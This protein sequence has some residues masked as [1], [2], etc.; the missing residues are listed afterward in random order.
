MI[1]N[2]EAQRQPGGAPGRV[3]TLDG[4]RALA[5]LGVIFV[6]LEGTRGLP[7]WLNSTLAS[8]PLDIEQL[9]VRVFFVLSGFLITTILAREWSRDGRI[10]LRR[11]YF[12]RGMKI[13]PP[14]IVFLGVLTLASA[15]GW[16]V[17][18]A[19][20]LLHSATF[21][22][23]YVADRSWSVGHLWALAIEEQFYLLWP[24]ALVLAGLAGGRRIA[25]VAICL[26]PLI[27]LGVAAF[28]PEWT[29]LI[30]NTF[31]TSAD[32]LAIGCLLALERD[33]LHS[34]AFVRRVIDSRWIIPVIFVVG[35]LLSQRFRPGLLLGVPLQNIA[36]ALAVER[37]TRRPDGR[38]GR[39]LQWRGLVFI[40]TISYSMYLWQQIFLNRH[41]DAP[42]A[43][44]PLNL[45]LVAVVTLLSY[46]LVERP[47]LRW[48]PSLE[49]RLF[50]VPPST[51]AQAP[52]I[53]A[54]RGDAPPGMARVVLAPAQN[55]V[56][57]S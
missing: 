28:L 21:T 54:S 55:R 23:N 5:M 46:Y 15:V 9:R 6:H 45:L 49:R 57:A 11:F 20:D 42:Y 33:R 8:S 34:L 39:L 53:L 51:P 52:G 27:R 35:A 19:S 22:I 14:M 4:L 30:G 32:A 16:L 26:V 41:S 50:G 3:P 48:R 13:L 17:V 10:D 37:C 7:A 1:H 2:G 24:P 31:E 47:V 43:A 18:P 38:I 36:I 12:R 56:D 29:P 44:F 40:A 25:L